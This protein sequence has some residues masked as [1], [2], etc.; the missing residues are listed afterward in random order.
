MKHLKMLALA[1]VAAGALMAFIGAGTASATTLCSTTAESCPVGQRWVAGTALGFSLEPGTS[2]IQQVGDTVIK[3]CKGSTIRGEITNSGSSTST[4]SGK[5]IELTWQDCTHSTV[6]LMLGGFEIHKITGTSNGTV[7]ATSETT[8][9]TKNPIFG[10]CIW[11]VSAG[12]DLGTLT[13]GKPAVLDLFAV[14][15]KTSG[16]AVACPETASWPATYTLTEPSSTTLS[17]SAG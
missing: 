3:T 17:V 6:T 1:A 9:T 2:L 15:N 12:T 11:G 16:S 13:E 8:W 4:V 10:S 14:I 5:I 7:T